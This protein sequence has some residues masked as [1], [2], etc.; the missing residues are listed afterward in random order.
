MA[1]IASIAVTVLSILIGL[2]F[3]FCGV[4]KLTPAVNEDV[5]KELSKEFVRHAGVFPFARLLGVKVNPDWYR[6]FIAY[7]EL[8]CGVILSVVPG[9]IKQLSSAILIFIMFGAV[10]S[11]NALGEPVVKMVPAIVTGFLLILREYLLRFNVSSQPDKYKSAKQRK[12]Y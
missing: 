7:V 8:L 12:A 11:L 2:F 5:Y 10:Y 1:K 6:Y 3:I 9:G 4:V